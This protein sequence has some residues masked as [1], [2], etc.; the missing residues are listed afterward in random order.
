MIFLARKTSEQQRPV[1]ADPFQEKDQPKLTW[2]D[3]FR[4]LKSNLSVHS[5][6]FQYAIVFAITVTVGML[7]TR[8]V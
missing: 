1:T 7:I 5:Q 2:Q 8:I 4:P 6:H 3:K